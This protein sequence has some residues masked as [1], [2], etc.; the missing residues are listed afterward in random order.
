M[1]EKDKKK[2]LQREKKREK[3]EE[4]ERERE[5]KKK[6]VNSFTVLKLFTAVFLPYCIKLESLPRSDTSTLVLCLRARPRANHFS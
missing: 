4:R 3:V 6:V 5:K 1:R 2:G